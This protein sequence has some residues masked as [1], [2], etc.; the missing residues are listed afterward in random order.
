MILKDV[1]YLYKK[2]F[3]PNYDAERVAKIFYCTKS[4]HPLS[5]FGP[6]FARFIAVN[7]FSVGATLSAVLGYIAG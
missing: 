3:W 2:L 1:N 7:G 4:T 6:R 5:P